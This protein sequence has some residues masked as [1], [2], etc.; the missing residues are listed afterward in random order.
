MDVM[1]TPAVMRAYGVGIVAAR[2]LMAEAGSFKLGRF[3]AALAADI[4]AVVRRRAEEARANAR[5][6]AGR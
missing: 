6:E 1:K 2:Q 5:A 3:N 4:E